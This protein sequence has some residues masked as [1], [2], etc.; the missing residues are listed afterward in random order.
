[1]LG[2]PWFESQKTFPPERQHQ[3][4]RWLE[5]ERQFMEAHRAKAALERRDQFSAAAPGDVSDVLG[6]AHDVF[7]LMN[8]GIWDGKLRKRL[9][10]KKVFQGVRYEIAVASLLTRMGSKVKFVHDRK[11]K[12]YD[13]KAYD[14]KTNITFAV[15]A[16]SRHRAGAVH[17]P[18]PVQ[19]DRITRGDIASLIDQAFEQ[20]PGG[21]PFIIFVDLNVP[22]GR[23]VPVEN[24]PWFQDV[25]TD[26]QSLGEP[27]S[28]KPDEFSAI[29]ITN[30]WHYWSG[31][32][33]SAGLEYLHIVSHRARHPLPDDL[34]GRI[35]AAIQN[36]KFIPRQV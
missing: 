9:L 12:H 17:E 2:K 18:G 8:A 15:E 26:M 5:S 35:M 32:A 21:I 10:D 25:W 1:M 33:I 16:K 20:N 28:D 6:L 11:R 22:R 29:F 36:Y 27:S 31:P 13:L 23:G 4:F 24:R 14:E 34:V 19:S 3:V 30:F 7:L